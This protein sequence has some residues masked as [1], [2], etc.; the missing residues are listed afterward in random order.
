MFGP[1]EDDEGWRQN[2]D[3]GGRDESALDGFRMISVQ[4]GRRSPDVEGQDVGQGQQQR[5]NQAAQHH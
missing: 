4:I 3:A 1:E 5:R 2:G